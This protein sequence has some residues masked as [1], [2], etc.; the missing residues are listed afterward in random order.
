MHA[1]AGRC[2]HRPGHRRMRRWLHGVKDDRLAEACAVHLVVEAPSRLH[3]R[4]GLPGTGALELELVVGNVA[5]AKSD[6]T[7][8]ADLAPADQHRS[9]VAA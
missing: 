5:L 6:G 1:P 8:A 3:S 7:R 4:K 2:M 9:V